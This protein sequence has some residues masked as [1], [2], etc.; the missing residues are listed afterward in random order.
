VLR[1]T[2]RVVL[3]AGVIAAAGLA[4]A[5]LHLN[6]PD[7]VVPP[8]PFV[9]K[10]RYATEQDWIVAHV[11]QAL[12]DMAHYARTGTAPEP[13]TLDVSVETGTDPSGAAV[14][15]VRLPRDRVVRLT[16]GDHI[17]SPAMY[18]PLAAELLGPAASAAPFQGSPR[19]SVTFAA[20]TRPHTDVMVAE[21]ARVSSALAAR[22]TDAAGHEDAALLY[23][24]IGLREW[25]G[26]YYDNHRTLCR[27]AAHLAM[28]EA[29]RKGAE[30]GPSAR[31]AAAT[32]LTLAF[33][34]QRGVLRQLEA[35]ETQ[36]GLTPAGRAWTRTLRM[37]NTEDW[38]LLPD[39]GRASLLERREYFV[40][41]NSKLG[42]SHAL[43]YLDRTDPDSL[44][45]W[46][47]VILSVGYSVEAGNRFVPAGLAEV[48]N[49]VNQM[50]LD[51][52]HGHDAL[53]RALNEEPA[54]GPVRTRNGQTVVEV[55]DSGTWADFAERH[56]MHHIESGV[57]CMRRMW[58]MGE[59]ADRYKAQMQAAFGGLRQFPIAARRMARS[60]TEYA[61]AMPAAIALLLA[62]PEWVGGHNWNLLLRPP[63]FPADTF[64][65]PPLETWC[66]PLFPAGTYFEWPKRLFLPDGH[67]RIHGAIL[68][69]MHDELP[70]YGVLAEA[71]AFDRLGMHPKAAD[72]KQAYG[73]LL[74]YDVRLMVQVAEAGRDDPAEP[75]EY[76]RLYR[77]VGALD[78]DRLRSL[79]YYLVDKGKKEDAAA[80]FEQ[81]EAKARD[82]V[83][84]CNSMGWLVNYYEDRKN[85]KRALELAKEAAAVYCGRG[86]LTG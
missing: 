45:D 80:V 9:T 67:L 73:P 62:G 72:L 24:T 36:P 63:D 35:F 33:R 21:S 85:G 48:M 55:I 59:A 23:A 68:Q 47:S 44:S 79:G 16:A 57:D 82:R 27:L 3:V 8:S 64:A 77:K 19:E 30:P 81:Y 22:M 86:L 52:A 37:R 76:E 39:P 1:S 17:W 50:P 29:L 6:R 49:E 25:A 32:L 7:P 84:V 43:E 28:A 78:P 69:Q 66:R 14:F 34:D 74:D 15:I 46:G 58:G 51:V 11:V 10:W 83:G 70:Y 53:I 12:A 71:A 13:T 26:Q 38:R 56:L 31:L 54:A 65:V 42:Q 4:L 61:A 2:V 20:L 5:I 18:A 40:W 41:L 60:R 75:L